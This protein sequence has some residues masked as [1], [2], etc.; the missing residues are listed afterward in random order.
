MGRS[1]RHHERALLKKHDFF[2]SKRDANRGELAAL[3]KYALE[4]RGD[5]AKYN[6]LV[7]RVHALAHRLKKL[8]PSDP[9]RQ[10]TSERLMA[11]LYAKGLVRKTDTLA[12][13]EEVTVASFCRRRL[14]VV[15]V[16]LKMCESVKIATSLVKKGHVRVGPEVVTDP[17]FLVTRAVEDLV[18]W[19]DGSKIKRTVAE[20]ND[21]VD[22]YDLLGA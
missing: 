19:A 4:E 15:L 6:R 3:R 5:Y 7:G 20:Y 22:D 14:P 9:F 2:Y 10:A 8:S 13:A 17:A 11:T 18:T 12:L 21:V 1:L 16:T